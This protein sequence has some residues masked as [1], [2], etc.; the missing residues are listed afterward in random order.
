MGRARL[1][2]TVAAALMLGA[3]VVGFPSLARVPDRDHA[4]VKSAKP[5]PS[6]PSSAQIVSARTISLP[7]VSVPASPLPDG[8]QTD[9]VFRD[10][11]NGFLANSGGP[12]MG[13][14]QGGVY[15][16][17]AGGI[18]R[19]QDGGVSWH[20]AWSRPGASILQLG[21]TGG[22]TGWAAGW[23]YPTSPDGT[24][25]GSALWLETSDGG[26]SWSVFTP[27]IPALQPWDWGAFQFRFQGPML[28]LAA[29]DPDANDGTQQPLMLRTADGGRSWQRVDLQ[30]WL[31]TGGLAFTGR[32]HVF[33]TGYAVP[34]SQGANPMSG[35]WTS[36][37]GGLRWQAVL[38][39]N[40]P[41]R[42]Y[43]IDFPDPVH[44][45]AAGGNLEKYG[46]QPSRAVMASDDGG[47]TWSLLYASSAGDT[48]SQVTRLQFVDDLHG[49]A[50]VGGCSEGAN[51][52]CPGTVMVTADGGRLWRMTTQV[53][54]Q[55]AA[56]SPKEAWAVA[57]R[58][59]S[60]VALHTTD[61]GV[62]WSASVQPWAFGISA[63][64]VSG[65]ALLAQTRVGSAIS[66]DGGRTWQVFRPPLLADRPLLD[67]G[68]PLAVAVPPDVLIVPDAQLQA[69]LAVSHDAGVTWT[70]VRLPSD[71]YG[72]SGF[73]LAAADSAHAYAFVGDQNCMTGTGPVQSNG[74]PAPVAEGMA[75]LFASTDG[76]VSWSPQP[77][78]PVYVNSLAAA[79]GLLAFAGSNGVCQRPSTNILGLSRDGGRTWID[80][81]LPDFCNAVSVAAPST[82]WLSCGGSPTYVL[83]SQDSARTWT[84]LVTDSTLNGFSAA[85]VASG[86]AEAWAYGP[87]WS[88]W[89]TT[90][91]GRT[92]T[93]EE[94]PSALG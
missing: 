19:T 27:A 1:A 93:A 13:T 38:I 89:H 10:H 33:A 87:A 48:S 9:V 34:V 36:Y 29:I 65:Q 72:F 88:L 77:A 22:S 47:R 26:N 42:L 80:Q 32:N 66:R 59:G 78:L 74:K 20:T 11:L 44:G 12:S 52:P 46:K 92:W 81:T 86:P 83:V 37:D 76:G 58:Q 57:G 35:I 90:D 62:H 7:P 4:F 73:E 43:A 49:W 28:G 5:A 45:F 14:D 39:E 70:P 23:Q 31:P 61:G 91:A 16:A 51:G 17:G 79:P 85:L 67:N 25:T 56:L 63:L 60:G 3:V 15:Q 41:F 55:L 8:N 2:G 84:K 24:A 94:L 18:G 30:G 50:A 40:L 54:L 71:P 64:A 53:A 82:I 75:N 68:D 21:L 69:G 6:F